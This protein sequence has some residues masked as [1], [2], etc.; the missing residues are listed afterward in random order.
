MEGRAGPAQVRWLS[1]CIDWIFRKQRHVFSEPNTIDAKPS[2]NDDGERR[3]WER[4][5][6]ILEREWY[7]NDQGYNDEFNPFS[8]ISEEYV[9]KR[10]RQI[11]KAKL[12]PKMSAKA[13]QIKK[14][15]EKWE[16]DRLARSGACNLVLYTTCSYT[17]YTS[18]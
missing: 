16:N 6:Y 15:N 13:Q 11:K 7:E 3:Q 12:A 10:E 18:C 5:Q 17:S 1:D 8:N 4:E 2:F 14:D 9:R